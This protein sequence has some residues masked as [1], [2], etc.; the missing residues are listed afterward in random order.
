MSDGAALRRELRRGNRG[1][2]VAS[3][4]LFVS[5]QVGE[6]LVPVV[7]GALI[8]RAVVTADGG[9]LVR[10]LVV[11]AVVFAVLST[12]WRWG[13]R[14]FTKMYE[15]A[16]HELRLRIAGRMTAH[17]GTSERTGAGEVVSVA[18]SDVEA[19]TMGLEAIASAAAAAGGLVVAAVALL[20]IDWR[21]GLLVLVG[22]PPVLL[23]IQVLVKPIERRFTEQQELVAAAAS[24]ATDLLRG[25]R[26]VKGLHVE[27][28]AADRYRRASRTSLAAGLRATRLYSA[29]QALTVAVTGAFVAVIALVGGRLAADGR[30][31]IGDLVAAVGVTQFLVAPLG[32]VGWAVG[33]LAT[34]RASAERVAAVLAREPG[35]VDGTAEVPPSA[36]ALGSVELAGVHHGALAGLDLVVPAGSFVG[37]AAPEAEAAAL[38]ELLARTTDPSQG[39]ITVD[40][41]VLAAWPLAGLRAAVLVAEHEAPLFTGSVAENIWAAGPPSADDAGA[42]ALLAATSAD[43][44]AEALP[45]GLSTAVTERGLS[46]SGGQRQRIALARALAAEPSVLV[47]H[48]PTTA[49]DSVTEARI[50]TGL[51]A[52]R[53]GATTLILTT[54]P[55]LLA[56]ADEVAF[57]VGGV[58]ADRGPHA[59]LVG[60]NPAYAEAVLT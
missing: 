37:V 25:L 56:E 44:V 18:S 48:D 20:V 10:W 14:V 41:L 28:N 12:S 11:L 8:D 26:V 33:E 39:T 55:A 46:L 58:V 29:Q 47:L 57:V 27:A 1:P 36:S 3:S 40:G 51:R 24:T 50:A 19:A 6:A 5:H 4:S 13:D 9:A 53:Q 45:D 22:L 7:A 30:I 35:V 49:I 21:L 34:A 43:E 52:Q 60:R 59:D 15:R 32:R 54:S 42:A 2:L 31:S 17:E 38:A 16:G 23:V